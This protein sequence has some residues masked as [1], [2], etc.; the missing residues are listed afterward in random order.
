MAR[1]DRLR[2]FLSGPLTDDY[3]RERMARGWKL[4]AVE[5]EHEIEAVEEQA[6]L[7]RKK[8]HTVFAS[9]PIACIWRRI[10]LSDK[11]WNSCST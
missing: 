11:C 1:V 4:V 3:L 5:W 7:L 2:E 10:P 6:S 9:P 8:Y